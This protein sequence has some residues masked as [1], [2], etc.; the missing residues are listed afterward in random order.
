MSRRDE[1][2][3]YEYDDEYLPEQN[4]QDI[5]RKQRELIKQMQADFAET[6]ASLREQF[7]GYVE[8][9]Q[10]LQEDMLARIK[11]L[12]GQLNDTK[13]KQKTPRSTASK[14]NHPVKRSR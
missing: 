2:D 12:K 8:E 4:E 13:N 11:E 10:Q 7:D 5:I 14:P 1:Y 6:I 3:D 9:T